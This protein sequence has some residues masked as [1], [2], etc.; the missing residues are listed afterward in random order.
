MKNSTKKIV[1]VSLTAGIVFCA[2]FGLYK[3]NAQIPS[4]I[5]VS[6]ILEE[7]IQEAY[8]DLYVQTSAYD[9]EKNFTLLT[10]QPQAEQILTF[11]L[12]KRYA[13]AYVR[14]LGT[15]KEIRLAMILLFACMAAFLF[16]N[17]LI[18]YLMGEKGEN[19]HFLVRIGEF[20]LL[21]FLV[22]WKGVLPSVC[23]PEKFIYMGEWWGKCREYLD[24]LKKMGEIPCAA[25]QKYAAAQIG[26]LVLALVGLIVILV[27]E[28]SQKINSFKEV[29][30][31]KDKSK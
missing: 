21:C 29:G 8:S 27:L 4:G 14:D 20:F 26:L 7:E 24:G 6:G 23:I 31:K 3:I 18:F 25:Y 15:E 28:K 10:P 12:Q 2:I 22:K 17:P 1:M 19:F 16:L 30:E 5:L 13:D 11:T 9:G